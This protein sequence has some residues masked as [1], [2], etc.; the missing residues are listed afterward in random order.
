[1]SENSE[2]NGNGKPKQRR[3]RYSDNE[4][5]S[6]LALV[7]FNS[8]LDSPLTVTSKATQIADS[9]IDSWQTGRGVSEEA[10]AIAEQ[11]KSD[12]AELC[13]TFA[14]KALEALVP[15][16]GNITPREFTAIA[17]AIDKMLLL[18]GHPTQITEHKSPAEREKRIAE[19]IEKAKV[20]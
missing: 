4:K 19:L 2:S 14:R 6:V 9:T 8:N 11:K 12:L 15:Q 13:E 3:R 1:M 18:R 16:A 10:K 5:A 17:I 7:E 20:A